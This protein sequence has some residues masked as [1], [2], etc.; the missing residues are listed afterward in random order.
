M[1]VDEVMSELES[2]G[3]ATTKNTLVKHGAREPF[4]GVKIEDMKKKLLKRVKGD[5]QLILALYDTGNSDAMYLAGLAADPIQMTKA[6]L[7]RWAKG[8]YWHMISG[9]TVPGVAAESKFAWELALEWIDSKQEQ[10][11]NAGWS[12]LAAWVGITPD[13]DLPLDELK[14]LLDRAEKQIHTAQNRVR[15]AMNS[16]VIAAGGCVTPLTKHATAVAK[17]IGKV[18]VD[19]GGTACKVPLAADYIEMMREKGRLGKKRASARC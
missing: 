12:T 9:Y 8:A 4:F 7:K 17:R 18:E 11:A 19:M 5:Q 15:Y 10:I 13:E 3:N 1:T 16:F 6:Q 2:L 14:K